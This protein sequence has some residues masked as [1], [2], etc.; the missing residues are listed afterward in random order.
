VL[1]KGSEAVLV[2]LVVHSEKL[3]FR[4]DKPVEAPLDQ[5]VL[6]VL[7]PREPG[8]FLRYRISRLK[9]IVIYTLPPLERKTAVA[10]ECCIT[11]SHERLEEEGYRLGNKDIN[12][13][14]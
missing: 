11:L 14:I 4:A 13:R 12:T 5:D 7:V 2:G 3:S 6:T 1:S 9:P 8:L 10:T